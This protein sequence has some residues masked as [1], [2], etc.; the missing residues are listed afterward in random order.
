[1]RDCVQCNEVTYRRRKSPV[2]VVCI[3]GGD[4]AYIGSV[5]ERGIT[6][7]IQRFVT[8]GCSLVVRGTMPSFTCPNN[9]SIATGVPAAV[10][11]V[12]GNYHLDRATNQPVVMTGPEMLRV[13]TVMTEYARHG[14]SV[15]SITAK[16]KLRE[17]LGKEMP[18]APGRAVN[19]SAQYAD[20]CTIAEHGIENLL[21]F[22]ERPAPD[23]YSADLSLFVLEAGLRLLRT[24]QPEL[25]YLSLTDYIQHAYPPGHP[26]ADR[27]YAALDRYFG[28]LD[29]AGVILALTADHGMSDMANPDGSPRV[30]WLQTELDSAFGEGAM[31]VI[32]PITDAFVGHHGALGGFV[33]VYCHRP[34]PTSDVQRV[35]KGCSG[36]ERVWTRDEAVQELEV[37]WDVEADFAVMAERGVALGTRPEQHDLGALHGQ[38]LRSH[39]S[40]CEAEVPLII[41]RP[42][43][44]EYARRAAAGGVRSH[45]VFDFAVNGTVGDDLL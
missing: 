1:M 8:D 23:M 7:N 14:V 10:H 37:P 25:M 21:S 15:V 28:E 11:G 39:G 12:S 35:L 4:P 43:N 3:D 36:V 40:L 44:A 24:Q 32:C 22:V 13:R 41:N 9:M 29:A 31:M 5:C 16:D 33:R 45:H 2:V 30:T 42:L 34:L 27:F 18:V 17:Q 6:P 26:E 20:R 19:F 38:R